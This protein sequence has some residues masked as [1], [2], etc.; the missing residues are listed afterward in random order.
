MIKDQEIHLLKLHLL[1]FVVT[2]GAQIVKSKK[3]A[4]FFLERRQ[5][6]AG[7]RDTERKKLFFQ[8]EAIFW[9]PS[10]TEPIHQHDLAV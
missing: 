7:G 4:F 1:Q 2:I 6:L 8:G 10:P 5:Q 9:S 3:K